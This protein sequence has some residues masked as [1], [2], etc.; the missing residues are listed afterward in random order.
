MRTWTRRTLILFT[1]LSPLSGCGDQLGA[2]Q[3]VDEARVA[4]LSPV[5]ST[6]AG[7]GG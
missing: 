4:A 6:V 7:V 5:A 1:G 2:G 3:S